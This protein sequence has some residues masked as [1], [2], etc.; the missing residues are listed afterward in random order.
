MPRGIN[1]LFED[2]VTDRIIKGCAQSTIMNYRVAFGHYLVNSTG[3]LSKEAC[4]AYFRAL[5]QLNISTASKNHYISH[6]RAFFYWCMTEGYLEPFKINKIRGQEQKFK[7]YTKEEIQKLLKCDTHKCSYVEHRSYAIIC[8]ILATG[9]RANTLINIK[10]ADLNGEYV[11]ITTQKNK[12]ATIIPLSVQCQR[13]IREFRTSW[14]NDSEW[15][16]SDRYGNQ[17]TWTAL[18]QSI[19]EY[20][21]N[22]GVQ[23]KG[24]HAFRHTFAREFILAGGGAFQ[25]Q[26]MLGHSTVAMTQKYVYLYAED[27]KNAIQAVTPLDNIMTTKKRG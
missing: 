27:V 14:K 9:A 23:Y 8:F 20:V 11:S 22:R 4:R 19:Q 26:K 16:F 24:I 2:F 6:L 5:A 18:R 21:T 10:T 25:L 13:V 3:E 1:E 12:K 15:L 17:L 7:A